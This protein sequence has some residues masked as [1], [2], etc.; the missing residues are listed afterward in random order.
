MRKDEEA[1]VARRQLS[2]EARQQTK[3]KNAEG[4][5]NQKQSHHR[6]H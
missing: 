5:E 2:Y 1:D 4:N 6:E 3:G